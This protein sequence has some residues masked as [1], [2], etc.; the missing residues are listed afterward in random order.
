MVF[1]KIFRNIETVLGFTILTADL[2]LIP[3]AIA[4]GSYHAL[5]ETKNPIPEITH[6][7]SD[8]YNSFQ[9]YVQRLI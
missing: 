5:Q 3:G 6:L 7:A 1:N 2:L 8:V 9:E 4:Y